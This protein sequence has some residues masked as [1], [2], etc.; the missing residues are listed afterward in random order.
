MKTFPITSTARTV[1]NPLKTSIYELILAHIP[2]LFL[3]SRDQA[4]QSAAEWLLPG[5]KTQFNRRANATFNDLQ[6]TNENANYP[7]SLG[8]FDFL[9]HLF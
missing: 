1:V 4:S 6:S 2:L 3:F 7:V 9:E 5:Y 8:S